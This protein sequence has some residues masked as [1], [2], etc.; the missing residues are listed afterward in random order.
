MNF[1]YALVQQTQSSATLA[2][3]IQ[4]FLWWVTLPTGGQSQYF[5]NSPA[6]GSL[7]FLPLPNSVAQLSWAQINSI[8][9]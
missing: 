2:A 3:D 9:S 6:T 1:E 5:L 8:R 7:G 4:A